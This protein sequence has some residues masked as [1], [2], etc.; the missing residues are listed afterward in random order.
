[1]T[2]EVITDGTG[3]TPGQTTA[4]ITGGGA[5]CE[6]ATK[7]AISSLLDEVSKII[8]DLAALKTAVDANKTA[9][10]LLNAND[11]TLKI[12]ASA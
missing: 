4:T 3:G 7:N 2:A 1:M 10:D 6:D 12:T 5:D 8:A 11:A 9:I